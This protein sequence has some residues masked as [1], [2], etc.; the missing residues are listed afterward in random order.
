MTDPG[1]EEASARVRP[2]RW[3]SWVWAVPIVAAAIVLWLASR[4]LAGRGPDIDI[5]FTSAHGLEAGQS[6]IQHRSVVIGTV[7]SLE[8][9]KDMSRV[10]VHARMKRSAEPSLTSNARFYIVAPRVS[11]EGISGLS[12]LVSGSYIE[13]TPGK[14]GQPQHEFAGLDDPPLQAPDAPGRSFLLKADDLGSLTR[15]S[16][17]TY[18]GVVVGEV[19][20]Y[21]LNQA[22]QEVGVTVFVRAPY[23]RLVHPQTRFWNAGGVDVAVGAQ[24]VRIRANSWQQLLAG[25]IS[26]ETPAAALAGT[27]AAAGSTFMLYENHRSSMREP[28]GEALVYVAD[29]SGNLRGVD[30]G[31]AVELE[32]VEVGE[33]K[34]SHL[35]YDSKRRT[36][37]TLVTLA[38]D[39]T[40]VKIQD[41]PRPADADQRQVVGQWFET[42]VANGLRAQVTTTSFLTGLK[43]VGLD[44]VK[45]APAARL[46]RVGEYVRIPTAPSGD[47]ADI[48]QSL[49]GVLKN[50]DR[51]TAG[52]ELGHALKSLDE[53]MTRLDHLTQD[54]E[55]DLKALIKSLRDT[56]DAAQGTLKSVQGA[57]GT[58]G[59]GGA[60]LPR[61]MREL[62][63]AARSVRGLADYLDRH[64]EALLRGRS[65]D[66]Q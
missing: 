18:H 61:L 62:T 12:T 65:G 64:P 3:F 8:L 49:R 27:P 17:I 66:D 6:T 42:L 38:I 11:A 1:D 59:A 7:E 20:G 32:G 46:E 60:D 21:T 31:T 2:H 33:V 25:G 37:V 9:T 10:I 35:K 54:V 53:T 19:Q 16:Q 56:S 45:D 48:L 28:R 43:I 14:G 50:V 57:I 15:G 39:P 34:E 30:A 55:P 24:G 51:A 26:F 36:L 23:D 58:G 52:P 29:F 44:M 40:R 47:I 63:E 41:M 4:S 13:M 22:S 5:S